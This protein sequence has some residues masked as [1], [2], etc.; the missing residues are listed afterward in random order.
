MKNI[1]K[2]MMLLVVMILGCFF[3]G[4]ESV[5]ADETSEVI[6]EEALYLSY[7]VFN[8]NSNG[9]PSNV[10]SKDITDT[11]TGLITQDA[12]QYTT[13]RDIDILVKFPIELIANT[14]K[15]EICEII[16][17]D[18]IGATSDKENCITYP[19][20]DQKIK[21]QIVGRQDGEKTIGVFLKD[22]SGSRLTKGYYKTIVGYG[23]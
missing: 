20:T 22:H 9:E 4:V 5:L 19:V 10:Y 14:S 6:D 12:K 23:S 13:S 7:Y 17:K 8:P 2:Y 11:E 18:D 3:A 1:K 16:P 15:Y 21:Y